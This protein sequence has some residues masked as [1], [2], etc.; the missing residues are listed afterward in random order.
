[1]AN[2]ISISVY[3]LEPKI[4]STPVVAEVYQHGL[5]FSAIRGIDDLPAAQR[6]ATALPRIYGKVITVEGGVEKEYLVAETVA[7]ILTKANAALS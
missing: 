1:M 5:P 3:R 2:L 4:G 7:Q 6:I